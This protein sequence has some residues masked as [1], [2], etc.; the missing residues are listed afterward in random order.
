MPV[1]K[2]RD[3][4]RLSCIFLCPCF[5]ILKLLTWGFQ[6]CLNGL[7]INDFADMV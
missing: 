3:F 1:N 2:S 6:I 4:M 5:A 7:A